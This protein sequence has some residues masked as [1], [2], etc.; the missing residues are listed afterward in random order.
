MDTIEGQFIR[1][2]DELVA[3]YDAPSA[4]VAAKEVDY[5]NPAGRAFIAAAPFLLLATSGRQGADVSP[6]GDAPGFVTVA[7]D[8]TLLIPDRRGNN[9][10]DGLRNIVENPEVGVLF[11]VPGVDETYRVNGP[12]RL[13]VETALRAR[14]AV[15]GKEPTVVIVVTVRQAFPHCAK[16]FVRSGLW[17]T[18]GQKR[19]AGVPTMGMF[20][21]ARDP[22]VNAADFDVSYAKLVPDEL[23]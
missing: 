23:Y 22:A 14:F 19:P 12:A 11:M 5:I 20:A 3:L 8:R 4:R 10:I 2:L 21:A 6:K 17:A 1:S 15:H 13:S 9:R 7:D 16:A 18:A